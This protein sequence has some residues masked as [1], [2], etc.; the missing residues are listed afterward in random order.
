LTSAWLLP[1]G[2][3]RGEVCKVVVLGQ[4]EDGRDRHVAGPP[5]HLDA[6]GQDVGL[7]TMTLPMKLFCWR[8]GNIT[9]KTANI[10]FNSEKTGGIM[11]RGSI[12][13]FSNRWFEPGR[14][15][16]HRSMLT[17]KASWTTR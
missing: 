9:L 8:V 14:P 11:I 16:I 4:D 10:Y 5:G 13:R 15:L 12:S 17:G 6:E 1:S 3:V 7:S 2:G